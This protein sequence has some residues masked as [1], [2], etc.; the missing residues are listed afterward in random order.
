MAGTMYA[1]APIID[2]VK[3]VTSA[4]IEMDEH[5]ENMDKFSMD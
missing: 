3:V 5:R 2:C 4:T 1:T